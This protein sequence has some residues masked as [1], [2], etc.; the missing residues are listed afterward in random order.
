M[1]SFTLV[2]IGDKGGEEDT[3]SF[4]FLPVPTKISTLPEEVSGTG[5]GDGGGAPRK[6]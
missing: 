3:A 4:P 5:G 6:P 1:L 2:T